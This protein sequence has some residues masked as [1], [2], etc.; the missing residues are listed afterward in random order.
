MKIYDSSLKWLICIFSP[1]HFRERWM[2]K[3]A[4]FMGAGC[5]RLIDISMFRVLRDSENSATGIVDFEC[6][7]EIQLEQEHI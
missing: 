1:D 2:V 4:N 6:F 7:P 3:Q 5:H